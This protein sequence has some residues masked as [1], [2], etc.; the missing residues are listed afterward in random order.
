MHCNYHFATDRHFNNVCLLGFDFNYCALTF[1]TGVS[2]SPTLPQLSRFCIGNKKV[3]II[4]EIGTKYYDFG[5]NL[6]QDDTGAKMDAIVDECRDNTERINRKVL[7]RWI[8][9]E[10]KKPVSWATLATE[11]HECGL[12]E[13][14]KSIRERLK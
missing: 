1:S 4:E 2:E 9:G 5:L 13:L 12:T 6:L 3:N 8:R 11:L 10:G 7:S 14:A